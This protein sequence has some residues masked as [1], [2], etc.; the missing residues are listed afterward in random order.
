MCGSQVFAGLLGA[1]EHVDIAALIAPRSLLVESGKQ[2]VIFPIDAARSTVA[3][4]G[5]VYGHLDA[6][7]RLVHDVHDGEHEWNG[8]AVA[9]FLEQQL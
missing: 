8:R 2:D 6:R 5:R 3:A 9:D 1:F 7:D 4:L